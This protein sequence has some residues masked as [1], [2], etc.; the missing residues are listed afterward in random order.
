MFP[1]SEHSIRAT[2]VLRLCVRINHE[3]SAQSLH[4][5]EQ[6]SFEHVFCMCSRERNYECTDG[7]WRLGIGS[8]AFRSDARDVKATCRALR[9]PIRAHSG[10]RRARR[11]R[12]LAPHS[13]RKGR[14]LA[15]I[16][17]FPPFFMAV[18]VSCDL[19]RFGKRQSTAF[20]M[21]S[22][23]KK[24]V[25]RHTRPYIQENRPVKCNDYKSSVC[26]N[27]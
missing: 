5:T 23:H 27:P 18:T 22:S 6:R 21:Y 9:P 1:M 19:C 4:L 15:Y 17:C 26:K 14:I 10:S 16:L 3:S 7:P 12:Q 2:Y 13:R 20:R 8:S 24:L 11:A 25:S